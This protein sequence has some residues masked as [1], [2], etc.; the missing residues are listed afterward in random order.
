MLNSIQFFG[1]NSILDGSSLL[2]SVV[3]GNA[4]A[5]KGILGIFKL[6]QVAD[7]RFLVLNLFEA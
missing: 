6:F 7:N 1:I 5:C 3:M 2:R 4:D